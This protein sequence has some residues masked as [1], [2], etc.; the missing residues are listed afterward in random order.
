MPQNDKNNESGKEGKS[1][2]RTPRN[3]NDLHLWWIPVS[4]IN[5]GDFV[6][7]EPTG[8][9][10]EVKTRTQLDTS[11]SFRAELRLDMSEAT[12]QA[13]TPD[14]RQVDLVFSSGTTRFNVLKAG[15][16]P[17]EFKRQLPC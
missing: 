7:M 10:Y 12:S 2:K 9:V 1:P 14:S 13:S 8:F 6:Y 4:Q 11:F 15:E 16:P 17:V 3:P 5:V